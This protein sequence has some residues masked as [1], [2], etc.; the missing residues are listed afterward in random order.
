MA[1][2]W[3][4]SRHAPPTVAI[5]TTSP[6]PLVA[7]IHNRMPVIL[8]LDVIDAWLDPGTPA[9]ELAPMLLS[10]PEGT[11]RMW[12]VSSAVNRVQVDGPELLR[13]IELEPT[14]GFA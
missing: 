11:L 8:P 3:T 4:A 1:G 2:I 7:R 13:P 14:L 12:P 9:A 6:N 5:L 10:A